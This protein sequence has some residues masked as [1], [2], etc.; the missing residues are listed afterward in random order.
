MTFLGGVEVR[1]RLRDAV[2]GRHCFAL[3]RVEGFTSRNELQ[4]GFCS[5][6]R[7]SLPPFREQRLLGFDRRGS[8]AELVGR[9]P[10]STSRSI[11]S[12]TSLSR[13]SSSWR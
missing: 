6:A 5:R 12:A 3:C 9:A 11:L 1:L 2:L 8:S 13:R 10:S 4:V 7:D